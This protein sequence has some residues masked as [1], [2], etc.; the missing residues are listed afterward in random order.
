MHELRVDAP[1]MPMAET[2]ESPLSQ[3]HL[4]RLAPFIGDINAETARHELQANLNLLQ[5]DVLVHGDYCLP[6]IVLSNW[7]LT[8]YI[9]IADS[10]M[11]D[12]HHDLAWGLWSL[13]YN[14]KDARCGELFL[15]AYGRDV[16]D[17]PRL[18]LCGLLSALP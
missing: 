18:R 2:T 16:V 13:Q 12:R 17:P 11:G 9:D 7:H 3:T 4:E 8:G 14:L 6:N 10:G 15:D 1:P 5:S